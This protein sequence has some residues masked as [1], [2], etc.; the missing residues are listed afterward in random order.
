MSSRLRELAKLLLRGGKV[1]TAPLS[2]AQDGLYVQHNAPFLSDERFVN[3]YARGKSTGSW[4]AANIQWR[5][6]VACWAADQVK[7]L[8]GDFIEF[9]VNKGGLAQTIIEY[10]KF[11]ELGKNYYLLDTFKGLDDALISEVERGGGRDKMTQYTDCY[12]EVMAR[13]GRYPFAKVIRGSV[14]STLTQVDA[15]RLCFVSM[16]MNCAAPELAALEFCW[17][18]LVP[19][20]VIVLD[21]YGFRTHEAQQKVHRSF[22]R[23]RG[24]PLLELPTGQGLIMKP[25]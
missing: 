11:V 18:K 25:L 1:A 14:P 3:A 24:V 16:D 19:G 15:A 13:F 22:A 4:G 6:H 20:G 10:L 17:P 23:E 7:T 8:P 21:D 9:G 2:Y 12:Q 5:A